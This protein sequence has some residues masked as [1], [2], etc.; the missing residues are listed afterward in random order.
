MYNK[1]VYLYI[2]THKNFMYNTY[3]FIYTCVYNDICIIYV[4]LYT[5]IT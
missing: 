1:H 5:C 3:M 2:Y 4:Y